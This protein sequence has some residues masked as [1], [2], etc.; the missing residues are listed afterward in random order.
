MYSNLMF[1][2]KRWFWSKTSYWT[3]NRIQQFQLWIQCFHRRRFESRSKNQLWLH[4]MDTRWT[5]SIQCEFLRIV[6]RFFANTLSSEWVQHRQEYHWHFYR[7][8]ELEISLTR[9]LRLYG[10]HI[11]GG[12]SRRD[13]MIFTFH[14]PTLDSGQLCDIE[15]EYSSELLRK[16]S[17]NWGVLGHV[18]NNYYHIL[19]LN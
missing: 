12:I 7:R 6:S 16:I 4:Q 1:V 18:V 11:M 3:L 13:S 17:K 5:Q 15:K 9:D 10:P 19:F 8:S 14:M 2:E